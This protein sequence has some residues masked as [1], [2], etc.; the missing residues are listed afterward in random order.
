MEQKNTYRQAV[1]ESEKG[2]GHR[3]LYAQSW[4]N[5]TWSILKLKYLG[6]KL[7]ESALCTN[8]A[9]YVFKEHG[10]SQ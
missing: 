5:Q 2:R 4:K 10:T 9:T 8:W 7:A 1:E 6:K 3:L